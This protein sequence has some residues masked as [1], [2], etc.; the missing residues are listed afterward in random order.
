MYEGLGDLVF[1]KGA[2]PLAILHWAAQGLFVN[3]HRCGLPLSLPR[4]NNPSGAV[5]GLCRLI[6]SDSSRQW[7]QEAGSSC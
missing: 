5:G 1:G 7:D 6:K 3:T 2:D 4:L